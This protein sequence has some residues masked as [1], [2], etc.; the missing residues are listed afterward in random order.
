MSTLVSPSAASNTVRRV[1]HSGAADKGTYGP[2]VGMY[3]TEVRWWSARPLHF[4][5]WSGVFER[6]P[7]LRF[8]V[9]ECGAF[10]AA[11]L[12]WMMDTA[13]DREHGAKKLGAQLTQLTE[14][15]AKYLNLDQNGPYKPDHYR[16]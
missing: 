15:Q 8:V 7:D 4:L 12:L 14:T 6:H 16:Y 11:D 1:L 2:Y 10:W 5:L 9:T 13:Y 3:V